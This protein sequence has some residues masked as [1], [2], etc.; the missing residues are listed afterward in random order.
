MTDYP[1][2]ALK[3]VCH[4]LEDAKAIDIKFFDLTPLSLL[5]ESV[6]IVSGSSNAHV[7]GIS[8][9]ISILL[10][11]DIIGIEGKKDYNWVLID[12]NEVLIHIFLDSLRESYDLESLYQDWIDSAIPKAPKPVKKASESLKKVSLSS[13]NLIDSVSPKIPK[14]TK[15]ISES[16]KKISPTSKT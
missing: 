2:L 3:N 13:K 1:S 6:V 16:P 11:K 4:L 5:F 14:P 10:K 9:K 7:K 15:K 12:Y 8:E